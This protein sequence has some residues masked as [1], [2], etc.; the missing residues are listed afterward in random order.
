MLLTVLLFLVVV[1]LRFLV[2]ADDNYGA[3]IFRLFT[4]I[5]LGLVAVC[6]Y[7]FVK[8]SSTSTG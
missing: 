7:K 5:F 2:E 3:N 6:T 4:L 1:F 8:L